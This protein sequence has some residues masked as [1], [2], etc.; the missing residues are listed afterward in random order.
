MKRLLQIAVIILTVWLCA[1]IVRPFLTQVNL[2]WGKRRMEMAL[3]MGQAASKKKEPATTALRVL[4]DAERFF[5]TARRVTL[6]DGQV[7]LYLA[8]VANLA[9]GLDKSMSKGRQK[10]KQRE[11]IKLVDEAEDFYIDN[12][13][14]LRRAMAY[15][16]LGNTMKAIQGLEAALYYYA[17]WSQAIRPI[18][19]S[20]RREITKRNKKEPK[21]ILRA[22]ERLVDRFPKNRDAATHLGRLYLDQKRSEEARICFRKAEGGKK[23]NIELGRLI[24]QSYIQEGD[25]R[26][27]IWELCRALHFSK[28]KKSKDLAPVIGTM[29][30]CLARD[31]NNGDGHFI[32]GTVQQDRLA[33]LNAAR[34]DY[35]NAY[36]V[37][38]AH[39]E[40]VERLAEVCE[41]LG[42]TEAA[43]KWREVADK[44]REYSKKVR[45]VLPSGKKRDA[46]CLFVAEASELSPLFGEVVGD[47]AAS[48]GKAVLLSKDN[49]RSVPISLRCPPLP[50]GDYEV[51]VRMKVADLLGPPKSAVA[52]LWVQGESVQPFGS[53]K[54]AKP[55]FVRDFKRANEYRDFTY[56]F[57]HPG[58][59]DYEIRIEYK[60]LCDVYIDRITVGFL[61][62]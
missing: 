52:S 21:R 23:G 8:N 49:G 26:R 42:D 53:R 35:R 24:A 58:L 28:A 45:L 6:G 25:F 56:G 31:P 43:A 7:W 19:H 14:I 1:T 5:S 16:S 37:R 39:L 15:S 40:T 46:Y 32:M 3:K 61:E 55:V 20:Y 13:M 17:M 41:G 18:V 54:K 50:A 48:S 47:D 4:R 29:R 57:Y 51:S 22:M 12:N 44:I 9:P 36:K 59:V 11:V 27:A 34:R 2:E 10:S 62:D 30:A 38:K 33:D 60:A